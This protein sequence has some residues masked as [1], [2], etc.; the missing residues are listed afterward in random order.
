MQNILKSINLLAAFRFI[1]LCASIIVWTSA[2]LIFVLSTF[3]SCRVFTASQDN[4]GLLLILTW[5]AFVLTVTTINIYRP[6]AYR[7]FFEYYH[8]TAW[9]INAF[10]DSV[11]IT[12]RHCQDIVTVIITF[13]LVAVS[14][15]AIYSLFVVLANCKLA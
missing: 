4:I 15:I 14:I 5:I 13:A 9:D 7:K 6:A 12:L 11:P 2:T 10:C 8:S 1:M 3:T